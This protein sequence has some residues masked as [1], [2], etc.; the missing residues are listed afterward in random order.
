MKFDWFL[1]KTE[2]SHPVSDLTWDSR[3]LV[4]HVIN[5]LGVGGAE[6]F[7]VQ[8]MHAQLAR[9]WR[10]GVVTLVE[11]NPLTH[12]IY[13]SGILYRG[14]GRKR[15]NDP[16]LLFDL[17]GILQHLRPDVVHTHL[18]YADTFGA[19]AARLAGIRAILS[20]EHSTE[21]WALSRRRRLAMRWSARW[22]RQIV[23]VS[24]AVRERTAERLRVPVQQIDVVPNGIDLEPFAQA[25]PLPRK[26]LGLEAGDFVLGCVGRMV[27]SKGYATLLRALSRLGDLE[28]GTS[29]TRLRLLMVG[30]GPDRGA[31]QAQAEE[32][33]IGPRVQWLGLRHDV[34]RLL[35]TI[36]LFVM[37]S[38]Y[39]GHSIALLEAMAAGRACLVSDLPEITETTA[40][41]AVRV[42]A[43]DEAAIAAAL[44]ALAEDPSRREALGAQAREVAGRFSIGTASESYLRLYAR[45]L[46]DTASRSSSAN[47]RRAA[48]DSG[49]T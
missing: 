35:K 26:D 2:I 40:A 16:R 23:A 41:S 21:G 42:P 4:V 6:R 49:P 17:I 31:L 15:L 43:G 33:G 20:T 47:R 27:E 24:D 18:F 3:P 28:A 48:A 46:D 44:R 37:P 7:L 9:G 29:Q 45:L 34:A 22:V 39:E 36:D 30:E 8:L 10:V 32:S 19:V 25:T 13:G 12:D 1:K 11:P 38:S 5:N 14:C